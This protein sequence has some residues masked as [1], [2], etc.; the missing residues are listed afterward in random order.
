LEFLESFGVPLYRYEGIGTV[1]LKGSGTGTR[2]GRVS[3]EVRQLRDGEIV[4][5][6]MSPRHFDFLRAQRL[7]GWVREP[8]GRLRVTGLTP[9]LDRGRFPG[10]NEGVAYVHQAVFETSISKAVKPVELQF[11]LANLTA[12][13]GLSWKTPISVIFGQYELELS[14][15]AEY[16]T[17]VEKLRRASGIEWTANCVVRRIN[18]GPIQPWRAVELIDSICTPL[19]LA[20]GTKV[21]WLSY[22]SQSGTRGHR[23][24]KTRPHSNLLHS[25]GWQLDLGDAITSW[26]RVRRKPYLSRMTNYF[27]DA[28]GAGP[29]LET[30]ALTAASLLDALTNHFSRQRGYDL[31]VDD[32]AWNT[33]RP[34][35]RRNIRDTCRSIGISSKINA[36]VNA[37]RRHPLSDKLRRLLGDLTLPSH[38]L[39]QVVEVR[40]QIVHYGGFPPNIEPFDAYRLVLWTGFAVLARLSGYSGAIQGP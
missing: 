25:L 13:Q 2:R 15:V 40:D 30:R 29:Y 38:P 34:V 5:G 37:L 18:G 31:M 14:P 36:N 24:S 11:T 26:A 9:V 32:A 4:V 8:A 20:T 22:S 39:N 7:S 16:D 6:C 3:F 10:I 27:L 17:L 33:A 19:S 1:S 35:L 21:T 23:S 28:A 12:A